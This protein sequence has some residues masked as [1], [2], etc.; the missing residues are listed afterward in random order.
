MVLLGTSV[1]WEVCRASAIAAASRS[2][3]LSLKVGCKDGLC[4]A[5]C[6]N[7]ATVFPVAESPGCIICRTVVREEPREDIKGGKTDDAD[8]T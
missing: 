7:E 6:W 4:Y 8:A 3:R 5:A 1:P 2:R